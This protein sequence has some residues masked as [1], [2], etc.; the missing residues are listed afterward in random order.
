MA[1]EQRK[2]M[3]TE[4]TPTT[5]PAVEN[6][7]QENRQFP[8]STE[9]ASAAVAQPGIY[10]EAAADRPAFWARQARELLT[11][12]RDFETALDFYDAPFAKWFVSGTLN[13]AYNALDR[14]VEN[15]LG[16]R[17]AIYF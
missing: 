11:W 3:Q 8:P 6:L 9:F 14:H 13:A 4:N 2:K 5:A 7:L 12:E 16:D 1:S 10:E 15:G 17:V